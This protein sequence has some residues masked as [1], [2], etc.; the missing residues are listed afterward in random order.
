MPR[1]RVLH[2]S[3]R[4]SPARSYLCWNN[5]ARISTPSAPTNAGT[6]RRPHWTTVAQKSRLPHIPSTPRSSS[7][8]PFPIDIVAPPDT[9]PLPIEKTPLPVVRS[10]R[11][12]TLRTL[13][14]RKQLVR[15]LPEVI[16]PRALVLLDSASH[17]AGF[18]VTLD[19][20]S[21]RKLRS[22]ILVQAA[23]LL[24]PA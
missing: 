16:P 3:R 4:R 8:Y 15:L 18:G 1:E 9:S 12:E 17:L 14:V 21:G 7:H 24:V 6:M 13:Q 19:R 11:K 2:A 10:P 22:L 23:F 20:L 5:E